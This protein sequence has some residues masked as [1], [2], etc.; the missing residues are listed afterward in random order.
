MD[1]RSAA[2]RWAETWRRN[3]VARD[4]E[5][6]VALYAP[7]ANYAVS[8]FSQPN[9]G[10]EGAR[11][12][13]ERV[14]NEEMNVEAWFAE[15]IVD[16]ERAAVQWWAT[17]VEDGHDVSLAGTSVLRFDDHG[18]VTDEWDAWEQVD[19]HRAPPQKWSRA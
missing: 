14:L 7:D 19:G 5:P 9:N 12:Y 15:P 1:T 10:R 6:I 13:L 17:Y 18:L 3:W 11:T 2:R 16:G 4:P 8:P